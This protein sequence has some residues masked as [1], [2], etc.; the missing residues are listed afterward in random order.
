[1]Y[2]I[3]LFSLISIYFC[4]CSTS[5]NGLEIDKLKGKK[6]ITIDYCTVDSYISKSETKEYGTIFTEYIDLDTSCSWNGLSRGFFED[7]FKDSV[8]VKSMKVIERVDYGNQEFTTYL[9]DNKYY[10][11]LIYEFSAFEDKFI[12]DYK[13]EY[14]TK[15]IKEKDVKY[16]NKYLYKPRFISNYKE[17]LVDK[18]ML[19]NYFGRDSNF[20]F[21]Q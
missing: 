16:E 20:E 5:F 15:L 13:G 1:M 9:I 7:L 12:I 3:I 8:D 17:S 10:M 11:N 19:N 2:K 14:F 6:E 18:N 4:A 21:A